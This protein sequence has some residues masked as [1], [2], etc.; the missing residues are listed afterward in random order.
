MWY[1]NGPSDG[2]CARGNNLDGKCKGDAGVF[3]SYFVDVASHAD[4]PSMPEYNP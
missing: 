1:N 3:D 4:I 2:F